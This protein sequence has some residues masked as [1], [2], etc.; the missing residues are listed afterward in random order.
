MGLIV[1]WVA[2]GIVT[3]LAAHARN[4]NALIWLAIGVVTGLFGLLAV[5]VMQ[6]GPATARPQGK[7][8][9]LQGDIIQAAGMG[10]FLLALI[11]GILTAIT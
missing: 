9:T 1:I 2:F 5:L 3:A 4:R 6:P 7:E 10:A 11:F 8:A